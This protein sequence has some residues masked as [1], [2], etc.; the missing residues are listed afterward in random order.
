MGVRHD[1]ARAL[2]TRVTVGAIGPTT[3]TALADLG[4]PPHVVPAQS[5]MGAL[6]LALAR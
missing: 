4:V 6:V 1:L 5:S 3:A 2:Q